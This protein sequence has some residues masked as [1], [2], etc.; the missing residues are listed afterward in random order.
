VKFGGRRAIIFLALAAAGCTA[1]TTGSTVP[2]SPGARPDGLPG[3]IALR[4]VTFD[5]SCTPV[6]EALV[7]VELPHPVGEP[8]I[9]AITGLW[10]RQAIAV[11]AN[12]A[13]GCGVWALGLA[14]G[15]SP[16]ASQ[17]IREEVARGVG[18]FG[19]TAS[20]VPREP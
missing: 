8:K 13:K 5:V 14:E 9:R 3:P 11:L 10:D 6:A 18:N 15:L 16:E 7:D 4:N 12:D 19:V 2:T 20:P 1:G 17:E